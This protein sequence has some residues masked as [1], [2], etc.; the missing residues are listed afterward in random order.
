M[1]AQHWRGVI[2]TVASAFL[3]G[4]MPLFAKSI[5]AQGGNPIWLTFHRF[6][7]S[8]PILFLL[9]MQR[10]RLEMRLHQDG[11]LPKKDKV[12]FLWMVLAF[13]FT[14]VLLFASYVELSGGMATV[15]HFIYPVLVVLLGIFFLGARASLGKITA[16]I[17]CTGG[18]FFCAL[19]LGS[20]ALGGAFFAISSALTYALYVF[21]LDRGQG[22]GF[23]VMGLS[24]RLSLFSALI[25]GIVSVVTGSVTFSMSARAWFLSIAF[26]ILMSCFAVLLF[27]YG[28]QRIG[29]DVASI[30]STFEPLT[31][32][33]VG[34]TFLQEQF[35]LWNAIGISCILL[36][37]ILIL[38]TSAKVETLE[39]VLEE[40]F[41][42]EFLS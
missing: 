34:I 6:A 17:L 28:V 23:S 38:R 13:A 21:F 42:E 11:F 37:V 35:T 7:F 26:S 31:G 16:V 27:Q 25:T 33:V 9:D 18:V 5:Y 29:G 41:E 3:F 39:Q 1:H 12:E 40:E 32:V 36:S 10:K 20:L 22:Y 30:L 15:L 2:A 24:W 19:P 4:L 14:P 8:F